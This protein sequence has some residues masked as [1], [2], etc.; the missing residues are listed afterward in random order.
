MLTSIEGI[1]RGFGPGEQDYGYATVREGAH[2]F[3]WLYHT[4]A[5]VTD[6]SER[7]LILWLVG[8]PGGSSC[9]S[10]NFMLVGPLDEKLNKREDTW[11]S[12]DRKSITNTVC[13]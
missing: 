10:G 5:N 3:W 13:T 2:M 1:N 6:S 7:P 11:V 9:G 8:G 12:L 4:T